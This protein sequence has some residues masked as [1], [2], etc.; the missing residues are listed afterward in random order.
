M[1]SF[2]IWPY[3]GALP[4]AFGIPRVEVHALLGRPEFTSPPTEWRSL[5]DSWEGATIQVG[6]DTESKLNHVGFGPGTFSLLLQGSEFWS[7]SEH[8][9]PNPFLLRFDPDPLEI[10]GFLIFDR[11]G[12][13]TT[14]YHDDDDNDRAITVY[15]RGA[16]DKFLKKG[17]APNLTRY[18]FGI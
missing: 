10:L 17:I 9:D 14:G 16:W 7:A 13:T 1:S 8:A 3:V 2:D 5:C 18:K 12:V 15:P 6:Y 11:I 4:L